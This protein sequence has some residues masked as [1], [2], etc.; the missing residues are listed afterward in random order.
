KNGYP[1]E[2]RFPQMFGFSVIWA[3]STSLINVFFTT[4]VAYVMA[5]YRFRGREFLYALGIF[6]M[7]TPIVG[8]FPS[9]MTV[10]KALHVYDNMLLTVITTPSTVFSGVHFMLMFAAFKHVSW[11]YAE[12]AFI[13]GASDHRVMYAIM[14]PLVLPTCA[15]LFVLQFLGAWNDYGT[16]IIWLPSYPTLAYGMLTFQ[17]NADK[18]GAT[19]PEIMAGFTLVA[20]PNIIL[21][22]AAQKLI[23]AKFTVG[24]LKE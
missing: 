18:Y 20:I 15:V 11:T 8:N 9:A 17:A 6:V 1:A 19:M 12:A 10:K 23:L 24:G 2:Y 3:F 22:L 7:I 21:Y 5:K 4:I 13:D 14:I 16:F